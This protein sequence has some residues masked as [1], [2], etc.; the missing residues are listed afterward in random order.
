[1]KKTLPY[2]I[3]FILALLIWDALVDPSDISFVL[4]DEDF[5][6]PVGGLLATV[7]AGGGILIGVLVTMFVAFVLV[8]VFAGVS[9]VLI[10]ALVLAAAVTLVAVSPLLLPLLIPIGI[11][12]LL[13][14]RNRHRNIERAPDFKHTPA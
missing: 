11:V 2:L 12:W 6:G 8:I 1:M 13:A 5:D 4:G 7:L 3:L 9:V 14:R 10:A